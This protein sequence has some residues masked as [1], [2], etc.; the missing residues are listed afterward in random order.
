MGGEQHAKKNI[1]YHPSTAVGPIVTR[2]NRIVNAPTLHPPMP[3]APPWILLSQQLLDRQCIRQ[4]QN[5]KAILRTSLNTD[6]QTDNITH[7]PKSSYTRPPSPRARACKTSQIEECAS[8]KQSEASTWASCLP[9]SLPPSRNR[10]DPRLVWSCPVLSVLA[11]GRV[12]LPSS[13]SP[14][15]AQQNSACASHT[16]SLF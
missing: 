7:A 16:V 6:G 3:S 13:P 5:K 15:H 11:L 9:T 10:T 8:R 2:G 12:G 4:K 14:H 1:R